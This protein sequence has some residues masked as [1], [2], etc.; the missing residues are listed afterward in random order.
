MYVIPLSV[1]LVFP[2]LRN[3]NSP[4]QVYRVGRIQPRPYSPDTVDRGA[5]KCVRHNPDC[6]SNTRSTVDRR[7]VEPVEPRRYATRATITKQ[8]ERDSSLAAYVAVSFSLCFS[9]EA[10]ILNQTKFKPHS[11]SSKRRLRVLSSRWHRDAIKKWSDEMKTR[12]RS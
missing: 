10:W 9:D 11:K 8:R 2:P 4:N 7:W 3:F 1:N 6:S 5:Q 12:S